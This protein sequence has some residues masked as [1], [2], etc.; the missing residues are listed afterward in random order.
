MQKC[1]LTCLSQEKALKEGKTSK[2]S[3]NTKRL[4]DGSDDIKE[5]EDDEDA[6]ED[7]G[8]DSDD[9]DDDEDDEKEEGADDAAASDDS[10]EEEEDEEEEFSSADE[11]ILKKAGNY[12][13]LLHYLQCFTNTCLP[14]YMWKE[15]FQWEIFSVVS[16]FENPGDLLSRQLHSPFIILQLSLVSS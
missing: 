2:S 12:F 6:G 15:I 4:E 11:E 7:D 3:D 8:E 16:F 1:S 14:C 9:D 10:E 5:E 13:R